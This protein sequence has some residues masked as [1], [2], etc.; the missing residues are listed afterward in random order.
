MT[1]SIPKKRSVILTVSILAPGCKK[2]NFSFL[3][4]RVINAILMAMA[5]L[6]A[7]SGTFVEAIGSHVLTTND[8][9]TSVH[10]R[11]TDSHE[12]DNKRYLRATKWTDG[13]DGE[14][15][16]TDETDSTNTEER[17]GVMGAVKEFFSGVGT[18]LN[19]RI[20]LERGKPDEYAFKHLG[21]EGLTGARL[22]SHSNYQKFLWYS[23]KAEGYKLNGWLRKDPPLS[24]YDGWVDLGLQKLVDRG[25]P[26]ETIKKTKE[27]KTYARYVKE[28]DQN[29]LNLRKAGYRPQNEISRH[30][31]D[32]E[33]TAKAQ[34]W[35]QNK[36][37]DEYVLYALGLSRLSKQDL[38]KADDY[39]YYIVFKKAQALDNQK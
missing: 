39:K 30:A 34:I 38:L 6:F 10:S 15:D 28:F 1:G 21:L 11:I 18:N 3:V 29:V 17:A 35:A 5:T 24:T 19:M 33:M 23:H 8:I 20:W 36:M 16:S 26:M 25:I 31:S 14:D 12:T 27:F 37:T 7:A 22:T 9:P 2:K 13:G 4:M 32:M